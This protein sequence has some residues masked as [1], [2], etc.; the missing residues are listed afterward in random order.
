MNVLGAPRPAECLLQYLYFQS[1][2][3]LPRRLWT[4]GCLTHRAPAPRGL[5]VAGLRAGREALLVWRAVTPPDLAPQT[6]WGSPVT[7]GRLAEPGPPSPAGRARGRPLM[8]HRPEGRF[9]SFSLWPVSL[10]RCFGRP[11]RPGLSPGASCK[12]CRAA[13][14]EGPDA[15][16]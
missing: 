16:P 12:R 3:K 15:L 4:R 5:G 1:C 13:E 8:G 6:R 7:A 2:K 14:T 9:L 11:R 10:P